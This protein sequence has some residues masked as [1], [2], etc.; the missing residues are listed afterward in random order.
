M[1]ANEKIFLPWLKKYFMQLFATVSV[2]K[3]QARTIALLR[4]Y[5]ADRG[6]AR[7]RF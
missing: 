6:H 3:A 4:S 5:L 7:I 2:H 1:S